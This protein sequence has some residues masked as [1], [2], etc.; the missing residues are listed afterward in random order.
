MNFFFRQFPMRL[1]ISP[2]SIWRCKKKN[3][4]LF[5]F[6]I[7]VK[8]QN[9][10]YIC[11][12]VECSATSAKMIAKNSIVKVKIQIQSCFKLLSPFNKLLILENFPSSIESMQYNIMSYLITRFHLRIYSLIPQN[13]N[14]V[15]TDCLL[16]RPFFSIVV[17]IYREMLKYICWI[18]F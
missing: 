2:S 5:N 14:K 4:N 17:Y 7:V 13:N 18:S 15:L 3:E 16:F 8:Q 10:Y 9:H 1:H 6:I 11:C 12:R